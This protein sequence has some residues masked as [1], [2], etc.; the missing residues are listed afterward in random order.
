MAAHAGSAVKSAKY[1]DFL[2]STCRPWMSQEEQH[3]APSLYNSRLKQ[4]STHIHSTAEHNTAGWV[5][6]TSRHSKDDPQQCTALCIT[7]SILSTSQNMTLSEEYYCSPA[8]ALLP[9][10][11]ASGRQAL[12]PPSA[13]AHTPAQAAAG[14]AAA[15][16]AE[17]AVHVLPVACS[18]SAAPSRLHTPA[19]THAAAPPV[20]RSIQSLF[21]D[22]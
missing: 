1:A 21:M 16:G 19:W 20:L 3:N 10:A 15:A 4:Q 13:A 6:N 18:L 8:P 9:H 2:K 17:H 12:P 22:L 11:A 5:H 14:A 7:S